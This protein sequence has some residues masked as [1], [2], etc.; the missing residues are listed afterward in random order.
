MFLLA[1]LLFLWRLS[2]SPIQLNQLVPK[3]ERATA[4][5]PG[6][7]SVKLKS[8]GLFWNR[9]GRQVDLRALNVELVESSGTSLVSVPEV[10]I[11]LSGFA[12]LRGVVAL[13]AIELHDVDVQVV[14]REDGTFQIFKKTNAKPVVS[15]D[16]KPRDFMETFQHLFKV[17]ASEPNT[18]NPLSY[19]KRLKLKGAI[20]VDDRKNG[21]HWAAQGVEALFVGHQGVVTGNLGVNFSSPA[22]LDGIHADIALKLQ[23]NVVSASLGFAGVRPAGFATLDPRLAGL[24]MSLSG[25]INTTLTLPDTIDN[26]SADIEAGAGQLFYRDFY[27]EPLKLNSLGLRLSADVA[28]K[29]LRV[30]NLDALLGEATN[31]LKLHL[32]ATAQMLENAVAV[33]LETGL[34][35][36]RVNEFERYWPKGVAQGARR[37]LVTNLQAGSVDGANLHLDMLVPTGPAAKFQLRELKGTVVYSDLTVGYFGS[38]PPATG[39]TGSGTFDQRGFD[40]DIN[41]GSV[42]GVSIDSGKVVISGMDNKK[43]AISVETHLS[44]QLAAAFAVLEQPPLSLSSAYF[45]GPVSDRLGG[46]VM[47]GFNIA[48]PLQSGLGK[49]AIHYSSSGRITDASFSKFFRNYDLQ[50]ANMVFN[51]DQAKININGPLQFSGVPLLVSVTTAVAGPDKGH[52]ELTVNSPAITASQISALGFDVSKYMQGSLALQTNAKLAP[53][54]PVTA[55]LAADFNK[56]ALAI[57]QIH[58]HKASGDGGRLG[59]NLLLEKNHLHADDITVDLGSLK[60]SG[61]AEFD[62][63][64]SVMSLG[65]ERVSLAFAQL[66]DL[67]LELDEGNI[68]QFS[69]QGGEA[70]LEPFLRGGDEVADPQAKQVA[71]AAKV[72]ADQSESRGFVLK[73]GDTKLDKVYINKD[74]YFDDVQFSGRRDNTGWHEVSLSGH[75]PYASGSAAANGSAAA[76]ETLESGQFRFNFGPPE[77]GR[78]PVRIEAEDLGSLISSVK[79]K[80]VMKDGYLQINGTSRGPLWTKPIDAN[81]AM[82]GF[83]VKQAPGIAKLLNMVSLTQI[84]STFRQT[85]LAFN[86]ASGDIQLDGKRLSSKQTRM[87]GGSLGLSMSGWI[88]WEKKNM[89]LDG[90]FIPWSKTT[91]VVGKIPLLGQVV[92]GPDGEGIMAVD[93]T[94]SGTIGDP[95]VSIRKASLTPGILKNTLGV[96]DVEAA[97]ELQRR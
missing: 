78:Y 58:W 88:D 42:N 81:F 94:L 70:S 74:T 95:E 13:S 33:R 82:S 19:L 75:N 60:T 92:T 77:N 21:L 1:L 7:F 20:E 96:E 23:D 56:A 37:W 39:V 54:G 68:L 6:G 3:I 86:S 16:N 73:V 10:N 71:V 5:L 27:P 69:V 51:L 79:G 67:H 76:T 28:G 55:T 35:Q 32:T 30:S 53:G 9:A 40:L 90:T 64:G 38:L 18:D 85:G 87:Q 57:P 31:P 41:K 34:S 46:Q 47:A 8:I 43:A 61:K 89:A 48:L 26:L 83:T 50:A 2:A 17:L 4:D 36:L 14:R 29:T 15:A 49:D 84:I 65:L 63:A 45:S 25:T 11:S 59:F 24:D 93:F 62:L 52:A 44:G 97:A 72:P 22:A 66:E 91:K 80:D 12:L